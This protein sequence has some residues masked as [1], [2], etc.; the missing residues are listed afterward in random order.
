[1]PSAPDWLRARARRQVRPSRAVKLGARGAVQCVPGR[2]K[3]YSGKGLRASGPSGPTRRAG[4]WP[5][6]PG[7]STMPDTHE[8]TGN[9]LDNGNR[10]D[11]HTVNQVGRRPARD[12]ETAQNFLCVND[13]RNIRYRRRTQVNNGGAL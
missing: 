4:D 3:S 5:S 7:V 11:S 12:S 1:M 6:M 2:R 10:G 9:G 13:L 8:T